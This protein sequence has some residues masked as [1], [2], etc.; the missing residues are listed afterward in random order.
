MWLC[1]G[2]GTTS[3]STA[4]KI[5]RHK[6]IQIGQTGQSKSVAL[7]ECDEAH[8][9]GWHRGANCRLNGGRQ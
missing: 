8:Q 5:T 7:Q 1:T 4:H 3:S 2:D 9:G 6:D